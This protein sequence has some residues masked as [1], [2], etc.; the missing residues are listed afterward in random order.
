MEAF[1]RA[2]YF[3]CILRNRIKDSQMLFLLSYNVLRPFV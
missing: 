3:M 1:F 2:I